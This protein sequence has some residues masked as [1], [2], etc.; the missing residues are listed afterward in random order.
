MHVDVEAV[1]SGPC[2]K[3]TKVVEDTVRHLLFEALVK[4]ES[5]ANQ[6]AWVEKEG[7]FREQEGTLASTVVRLHFREPELKEKK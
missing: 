2:G 4:A 1:F 5:A 3:D 6:A 7:R